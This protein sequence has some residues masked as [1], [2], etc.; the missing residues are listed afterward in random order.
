MLKAIFVSG[1]AD[2]LASFAHKLYGEESTKLVRAVI[3]GAGVALH[4]P[5]LLA[6]TPPRSSSA[7]P[8]RCGAS[9]RGRGIG[10]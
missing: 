8:L 3:G 7:C 4:R 10:G 9:S 6:T 5:T 1:D 2:A